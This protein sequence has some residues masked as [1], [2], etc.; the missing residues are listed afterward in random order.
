MHWGME[1]A[2]YG[3]HKGYP[4][5]VL[6][7]APMLL[8]WMTLGMDPMAALATQ[9]SGFTALWYLDSKATMAG[10]SMSAFSF[11]KGMSSNTKKF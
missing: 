10:W 6:G 11:S 3:G 2:G 9:W 4:R 5:L 8:A 1:V 7:S